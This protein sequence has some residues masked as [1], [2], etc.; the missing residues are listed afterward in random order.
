[1]G[2]PLEGGHTTVTQSTLG[3]DSAALERELLAYLSKELYA[4]FFPFSFI[5]I[6]IICA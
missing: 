6:V 5:I 1:M 4:F 2:L 3:T